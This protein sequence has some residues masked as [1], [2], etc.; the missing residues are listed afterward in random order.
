MFTT[1]KIMHFRHPSV[2]DRDDS[3]PLAVSL[4]LIKETRLPKIHDTSRLFAK[5]YDIIPMTCDCL[6]TLGGFRRVLQ[7]L[8]WYDLREST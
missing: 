8:W 5:M 1:L 6:K 7:D 2:Y 3:F 4:K